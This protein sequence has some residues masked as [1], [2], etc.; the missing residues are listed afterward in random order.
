[1]KKITA[2]CVAVLL[3]L[4][5]W[6]G[7]REYC[8]HI[9][10]EKK[11]EMIYYN[12]DSRNSC[13]SALEILADKG[14]IPVFG[15]SELSASD[16]V[17]YPPVLF[18]QGNSDFNML[19]MGRGYMQ[20]L[21]HGVTLGAMADILPEKKV[22]L[23]LSPQW[24]T[25]SHLAPEVY[26][27]RFSERMFSAFLKNP[28]ISYQ[29][30]ASVTERMK[31]LLSSDEKQLKRMEQYENVYLKHT[32]NLISHLEL[33]VYDAFMDLRQMFLLEEDIKERQND[34]GEAVIAAQLD[35]PALLAAAEKAGEAACTNNDL[36]IYDE[37]YDTYVK[38]N[39]AEQKDSYVNVSYLDSL[40]YGDLRLFLDICKETGIEPLIVSIPVNGRWYDWCGF[41]KE[42]REAY[43]QKI[44]DICEEYQVE[45][46]D[47]S[48]REYEEYFLKD[49]MHLGW[50]GWVYLDE[51]VYRF[52]KGDEA[53]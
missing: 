18:Q 25:A 49:I 33:G 8:R 28:D 3:F 40:E 29:T 46:A 34:G 52:Y 5:T 45:I 2:F 13:K 44:R 39:M 10:S 23:I 43:Y 31:I 15:S 47:F 4:S 27:S 53:L 38:E 51:A 50:K 21:H 9:L 6:V 30:K 37:Y 32:F 1:M 48:D 42:G 11:Q 22:V 36:Y 20:S 19:L 24:F 12:L 26:A 16:Q 17:A 35:F 7:L 41:P 14:T